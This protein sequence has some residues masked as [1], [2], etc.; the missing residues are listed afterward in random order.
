MKVVAATDTGASGHA[1]RVRD[2]IQSV[3]PRIAAIAAVAYLLLLTLPLLDTRF[4]V[5]TAHP[6]D[7]ATVAYGVAVNASYLALAVALV[8]IV[9]PLAPFR[10]WS[11]V[12]P[13]LLVPAALLCVALA[14][15]P[16]AVARSSQWVLI[17]IV[18]LALAPAA[19][20]LSLRGRFGGWAPAVAGLGVA[21]LVAFAALALAPDS[22][23]GLVNRVF[24]V[25]AG[26]W[27]ALAAVAAGRRSTR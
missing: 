11:L 26:L 24:D 1:R 4:D 8:A 9:V 17:P 18:C 12:V 14:F 15:D 13:A 19:A 5:L 22:V 27:V 21:V 16:I 23:G 25:L 3:A 10:R 20:A 6:E 2:V 7:Y